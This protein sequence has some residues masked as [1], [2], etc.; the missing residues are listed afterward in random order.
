MMNP[1]RID[2]DE[3]VDRAS[4][5]ASLH[6]FLALLEDTRACGETASPHVVIDVVISS[7][8]CGAGT[9]KTRQ[10]CRTT[11]QGCGGGRV[12]STSSRS[13]ARRTAYGGSFAHPRWCFPRRAPDALH[14]ARSSRAHGAPRPYVSFM[15][16]HRRVLV[17]CARAD[18]R[19]SHDRGLEPAHLSGCGGSHAAP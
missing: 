4:I 13:S 14:R 5:A 15:T 10:V 19:R 8:G 2:H 12:R 18:T 9:K 11:C 16:G 7:M 6:A 17:T 3:S 1:F